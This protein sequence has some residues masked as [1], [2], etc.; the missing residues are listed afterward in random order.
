MSLKQCRGCQK[1]F[2][3]L[4][5]VGNDECYPKIPY[6]VLCDKCVEGWLKIC[7]KH[8]NNLYIELNNFIH[9]KPPNI[10]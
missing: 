1:D 3:F 9:P 10:E 5:L 2:E 7:E 4:T 6:L 8:H